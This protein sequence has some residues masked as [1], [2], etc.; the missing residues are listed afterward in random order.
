M[1]WSEEGQTQLRSL[2][3]MSSI[4]Y[5]FTWWGSFFAV[6]FVFQVILNSAFTFSHP[7]LGGTVSNLVG[8]INLSFDLIWM[9]KKL[10]YLQV[11]FPKK[12]T[13]LLKTNLAYFLQ[14]LG[15]EKSQPS[16]SVPPGLTPKQEPEKMELSP[17]TSHNG[18]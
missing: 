3:R 7:G 18:F 4:Y 12:Y 1:R 14:E 2:P 8:K 5:H 17:Q 16:P 11:V 9:Y 6:V 15:W 13:I 10:S